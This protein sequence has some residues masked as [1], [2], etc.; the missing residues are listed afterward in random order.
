MEKKEVI[1]KVFGEIMKTFDY[2]EFKKTHPRLL[3]S[4]QSVMEVAFM[5]GKISQT[6][7]I[8][9]QGLKRRMGFKN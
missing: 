1:K 2:E 8:S 3:L 9:K 4:I 6:P 7:S 5:Q